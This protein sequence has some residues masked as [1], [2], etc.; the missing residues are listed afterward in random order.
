MSIA[1]PGG[2]ASGFIA[3]AVGIGVLVIV[4]PTPLQAQSSGGTR[5]GTLARFADEVWLSLTDRDGSYFGRLAEQGTFQRFNPLMDAEYDL[6]VV[7][8]LFSSSEDARWSAAAEGLRVAG[9][10]INHPFILNLID[11]IEVTPISS[12]VELIARYRRE[13]TLSA[14]RDYPW[15]GLEWRPGG[16]SAWSLGAGIGAHFFKASADVQVSLRRGWDWP[17]GRAAAQLRLAALD[18]FNN[19]VFNLLGVEPG[20][21]PAHFSYRGFPAAARLDLEVERRMWRGELRMGASRRTDV[22]VSFPASAEEPYSRIEQVRFAGLLAE[23]RL[24]PRLI[25]GAFWAAAAA[26][27]DRRYPAPDARDL[28]LR[29]RTVWWGARAA[30]RFGGDLAL[31]AEVSTLRRPEERTS[32]DGASLRHRDRLFLVQAWLG[33]EPTAGWRWRAEYALA[34]RVA[35]PLAP[36]M[37]AANHRQTVEWGYRFPTRFEVV[38]GLRWDLDRWEAGIFDGGHLRFMASW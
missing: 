17:E 5:L 27:T 4:A 10:S 20:E 21:T 31:Q 37:S 26:A 25:L 23:A 15:F 36:G 11:W 14:R 28:S 24:A 7:T 18:A 30:L 22:A 32:G 35:G 12:R 6:D 2:R 13:H 34:D 19:T 8:G 33:R 38:A 3:A 1:C 29:E 16:S 9:A